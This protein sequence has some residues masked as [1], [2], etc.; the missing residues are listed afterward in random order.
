MVGLSRKIISPIFIFQEAES[1]SE[2]ES[3]DESSDDEPAP[4]PRKKLKPSHPDPFHAELEPE[5]QQR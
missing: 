5:F 1:G 3:E 4:A 2:N